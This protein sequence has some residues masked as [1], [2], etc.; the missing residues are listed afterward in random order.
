M[1]GRPFLVMVFFA[2][3]LEPCSPQQVLERL[4]STKSGN[5]PPDDMPLF[6]FS[7]DA[8]ANPHPAEQDQK[9]VHAA[10]GALT[11]LDPDDMSPKEALE[12]LYMLKGLLNH[13][14]T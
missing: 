8:P 6:S 1:K 3:G 5:T 2:S 7:G 13:S 4:E 9:P 10:L 14:D 12:A 11:D